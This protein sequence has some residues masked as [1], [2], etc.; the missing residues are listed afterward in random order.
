MTYDEELAAR[1]RELLAPHDGLTEKKMFG[2]I[3]FTLRGNMCCGVVRDDLIV[4]VGPEQY[5]AALMEPHARPMDFTGRPMKGLIY[6]GPGGYR[7]DEALA[8]WLKR[9]VQFAASLPPK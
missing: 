9:G 4:R 2:G 6:V 1:V 7:G 5:E 3:S 8:K